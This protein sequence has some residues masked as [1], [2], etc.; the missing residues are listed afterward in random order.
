MK[1][2]ALYCRVSAPLTNTRRPS[3]A[4]FASSPRI[5]ASK[6]SASTRITDTAESGRG[7]LN[8]TE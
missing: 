6:S 4:S 2:A 7:D 1:R 5:R 3:L 8:S